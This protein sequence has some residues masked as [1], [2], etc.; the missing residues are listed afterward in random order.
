MLGDNAEML[1]V[2]PK[3]EPPTLVAQSEQRKFLDSL[4]ISV[5]KTT[6]TIQPGWFFFADVFIVSVNDLVC[7]GYRQGHIILG[8]LLQG[9]S[10][11]K[12]TNKVQSFAKYC[13]TFHYSLP[14]KKQ[15]K[16]ALDTVELPPD[17]NNFVH[18]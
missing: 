17:G 12:T 6:A 11:T 18:L 5:Y 2:W 4:W 9:V 14:N 13:L 8:I 15:M 16:R 7:R 10:S 1:G 3:P